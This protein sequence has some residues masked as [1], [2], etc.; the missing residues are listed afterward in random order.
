MMTRPKRKVYDFT[1]FNL[2]HRAM[3]F[4]VATK[5][6]KTDVSSSPRECGGAILTIDLIDNRIHPTRETNYQLFWEVWALLSFP[7]KFGSSQV[8]SSSAIANI[9]LRSL[10]KETFYL[11][12]YF[13]VGVVVIVVITPA[14][15][16]VNVGGGG[17]AVA[18]SIFS[19]LPLTSLL[20]S[21]SFLSMLV[22]SFPLKCVS[23]LTR[24]LSLLLLSLRQL[25]LFCGCFA[26]CCYNK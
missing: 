4:S 15:T 6:T 3:C 10:H 5:Q 21:V 2:V 11:C 18:I 25:L 23:M 14:A 9:S 20:S 22:L 1:A 7:L 12:Y 26:R 13:V 16:A 8:L 24:T 17:R 19:L